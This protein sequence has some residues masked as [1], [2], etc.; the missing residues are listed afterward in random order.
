MKK[1]RFHMQTP[2][3][4]MGFFFNQQIYGLTYISNIY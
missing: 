1:K 3:N 4:I 2:I